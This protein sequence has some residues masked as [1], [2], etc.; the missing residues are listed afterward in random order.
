M[1]SAKNEQVYDLVTQQAADWLVA[2]RAELSAR[3]RE[4][5]V[6][7]LKVSPVHVEEYLG[8]AAVARDLREACAEL[9]ASTDSLVALARE[10]AEEPTP[11][12]SVSITVPRDSRR[13]RWPVAA[14]VWGALGVVCLSLLGW[15]N[16]SFRPSRHATV[17]AATTF[18]FSSRHGEQQTHRLPDDS[19]IHLNT[20]TSV[21][22]RLSAAERLVTL[23]SGE[24]DFEVAHELK[25]PFRVLAGSAQVIDLGTQFDVRVESD[26]AVITVVE[27]RVAVG[28]RSPAAGANS[29]ANP[30]AAFVELSANEQLRVAQWP[31]DAPVA[32]DARGKT[33]WMRRQITF[34]HEPLS[35]VAKEFNRYASKPI[36]ITTPALGNQEISGVFTIDDTDEFIAFLRSLKGVHV[37]VTESRILVSQD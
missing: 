7:W 18:R 15:W 25:R 19:V 37:E 35:S 11:I 1:M 9:A 17:D 33:S 22:V 6:A 5:F 10:A 21:T 20:D 34:E 3:E 29:V 8:V 14:V 12:G 28:P 26:V 16:F 13:G 32:A 36:V 27:G 2:N 30:Q 4:T 31:P 24:A 23:E